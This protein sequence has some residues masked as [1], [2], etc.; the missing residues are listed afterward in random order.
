[1]L[2]YSHGFISKRYPD[3]YPIRTCPPDMFRQQPYRSKEKYNP[4]G[5]LR[6]SPPYVYLLKLYWHICRVG[7]YLLDGRGLAPLPSMPIIRV[8]P[9]I[10]IIAYCIEYKKWSKRFAVIIL[11]LFYIMIYICVWARCVYCVH[12]LRPFFKLIN[13]K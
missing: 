12:L 1:M 6:P 3:I 8:S 13:R 5:R 4:E 7:I 9:N 11:M 10:C 2:H